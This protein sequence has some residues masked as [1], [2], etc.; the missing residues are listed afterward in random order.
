MLVNLSDK[1]EY[2]GIEKIVESAYPG[3]ILES[4]RAQWIREL[5]GDRSGES[6]ASDRGKIIHMSRH[7]HYT[8]SMHNYTRVYI[9]FKS[10]PIFFSFMR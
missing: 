1:I 4:F 9:F 2:L 6:P 10:F 5:A 8:A 3:K 7:A